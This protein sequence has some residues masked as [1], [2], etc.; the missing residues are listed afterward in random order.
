MIKFAFY[1][2][3]SETAWSKGD[4]DAKDFPVKVGGLY[5]FYSPAEDEWRYFY[6]EL[7]EYAIYGG[8]VYMYAF[9]CCN[10]DFVEQIMGKIHVENFGG[11]RNGKTK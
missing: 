11:K 4:Y 8:N 10:S 1:Y 3:N 6:V 2:G 9:S 7:I 5:R